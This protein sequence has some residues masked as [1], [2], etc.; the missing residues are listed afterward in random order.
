MCGREQCATRLLQGFQCHSHIISL[1]P[2]GENSDLLCD[3]MS[4]VC[5][6]GDGCHIFLHH[7]ACRKD[8]DRLCD[9]QNFAIDDDDNKN[10]N[11]N[12]IWSKSDEHILVSAQE[13]AEGLQMMVILSM[14]F[15]PTRTGQSHMNPASGCPRLKNARQNASARCD[16]TRADRADVQERMVFCSVML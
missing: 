12:N 11:N 8:S 15:A 14:K 4:L 3:S 1:S 9:S 5:D 6:E 7:F 2:C 10:K 13:L 16:P